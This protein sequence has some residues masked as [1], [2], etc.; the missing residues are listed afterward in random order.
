M[1]FICFKCSSVSTV[2]FRPYEQK[3]VESSLV[4]QETHLLNRYHNGVQL[5][6]QH[7]VDD[8]I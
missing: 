8:I 7:P 5:V 3:N 1:F 4:L 6:G 2:G